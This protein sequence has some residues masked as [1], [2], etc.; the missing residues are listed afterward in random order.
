M[1]VSGIFNQSFKGILYKKS[2]SD[3]LHPFQC[4]LLVCA[5]GWG[6]PRGQAGSLSMVLT[7][8]SWAQGHTHVKWVP[9]S[10]WY[11]YTQL[12]LIFRAIARSVSNFSALITN[13]SLLKLESHLHLAFKR[14]SCSTSD[15]GGS[16]LS[17]CQAGWCREG[18]D[19]L[20]S[21]VLRGQCPWRGPAWLHRGLFVGQS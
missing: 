2:A 1:C 13:M 8:L 5:F 3:S 16:Q 18:A 11:T 4:F 15:K 19:K 12:S 6:V 17:V 9:S 10:V 20:D 7:D 21:E 14:E